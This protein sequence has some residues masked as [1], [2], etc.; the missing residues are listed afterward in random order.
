LILLPTKLGWL[1]FR[2]RHSVRGKVSFVSTF[3]SRASSDGCCYCGV[4]RP[5]RRR[6]AH[7]S[8]CVASSFL[9]L[10]DLTEFRSIASRQV[11]LLVSFSSELDSSGRSM[12]PRED[13]RIRKAAAIYHIPDRLQAWSCD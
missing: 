11:R 5:C 13:V 12:P 10:P 7:S 3:A 2:S 9:N 8:P 4:R 1:L 6:A